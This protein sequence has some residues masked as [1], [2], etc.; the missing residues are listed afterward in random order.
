MKGW[1]GLTN[2][3]IMGE[4]ITSG[5]LERIIKGQPNEDDGDDSTKENNMTGDK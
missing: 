2:I 4:Y 1:L 5:I 3:L